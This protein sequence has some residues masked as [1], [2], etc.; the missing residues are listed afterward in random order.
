[1]YLSILF[2]F[3]MLSLK[4]SFFRI[5]QYKN[6]LLQVTTNKKIYIQEVYKFNLLNIMKDIF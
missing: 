5:F 1:M 2:I 6:I 4:L 3:Q